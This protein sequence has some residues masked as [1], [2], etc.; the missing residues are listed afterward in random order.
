RCKRVIHRMFT[1]KTR[2]KHVR[3]TAV[4][5]DGNFL[6]RASS[7]YGSR[8]TINERIQPVLASLVR[9]ASSFR[10]LQPIRNSTIGVARMFRTEM[11]RRHHQRFGAEMDLSED[12]FL[13]ALPILLFPKTFPLRRSF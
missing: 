6:G 12:E 8:T 13:E 3:V 1:G 9:V 2:E 11:D 4:T 5:C 7:Y 10:L